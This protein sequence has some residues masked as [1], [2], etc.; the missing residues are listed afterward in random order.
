V[1]LIV[2]L[3]EERKE[4][5]DALVD[6]VSKFFEVFCNMFSNEFEVCR[7]GSVEKHGCSNC[8]IARIELCW[9]AKLS[10]KT[11]YIQY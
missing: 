11:V 9:E 3:D 2:V 5:L 4:T 6:P 7:D 10:G 8:S 1:C